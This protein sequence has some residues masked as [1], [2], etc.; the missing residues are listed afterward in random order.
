MSWSTPMTA[1]ANDIFTAADF[2]TYVRDNLKETMPALATAAGQYF[3]SDGPHS[4]VARTPVAN[5]PTTSPQ[6]I[7][8]TT[9]Y[10][11][12]DDITGASVTATTGTEALVH[13]SAY[14]SQS[15]ADN[16]GIVSYRV[17]GASDL[18][19]ED[20]PNRIVWDGVNTDQPTR[21]GSWGRISILTPGSNTFRMGGR[22]AVGGGT[23][24]TVNYCHIIVVPLS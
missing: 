19:A 21:M 3:V 2:N 13:I 17:S 12:Y 11:D 22:V 8:G 16:A 20:H 24:L 6:N 18:N 9:S 23:T 15:T 5:T 7:S 1:V 4:L 14:M 10:T